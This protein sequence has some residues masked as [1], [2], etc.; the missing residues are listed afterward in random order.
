MR[1]RPCEKTSPFDPGFVSPKKG[2]GSAA[3]RVRKDPVD[4]TFDIEGAL[5]RGE[6][7]PG[8]GGGEYEFARVRAL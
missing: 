2:S 4:F 1:A 7:G 5:P 6:Y 3:A 8:T